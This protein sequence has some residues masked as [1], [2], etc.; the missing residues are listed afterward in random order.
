MILKVIKGILVLSSLHSIQKVSSQEI[1]TLSQLNQYET[2]LVDIVG[3]V[4][5]GINPFEKAISALNKA[6]EEG[7]K[8]VYMSNNPRPSSL[9]QANLIKMGVVGDI[10][11][12]TSGDF[13]RWCLETEYKEKKIYHFGSEKNKD[14]LKD[15]DVITTDN[16][17]DADIV[18][19]T[20]FIEEI[21]DPDQFDEKL[22][23]V[24]LSKKVVLCANPDVYASYGNSL[25]KCAG[26]FAQKIEQFGGVVEY[27]GKPN[28]KFYEYVCQKHHV[29]MQQKEKILMIGDTLYTDIKGAKNFGI[30]S[31]LVLSGISFDFDSKNTY[32]YLPNYFSKALS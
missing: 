24:A 28:P 4:Y 1:Q 23:E 14:I 31:L 26:F 8:I 32:E 6:K 2:M 7:H 21:E 25:R 27:L 17:Q 16:L 22:K 18:L 5:D 15:M 12:S 3:V 20:A 19:L 10:H 13:A 9:S 11:I 29:N 30:D